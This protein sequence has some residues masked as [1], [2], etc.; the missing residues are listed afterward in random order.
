MK[1][2]VLLSK[3]FSVAHLELTFL[4]L[5]VW[6]HQVKPAVKI[7]FEC[8]FTRR[9]T[10]YVTLKIAKRL[11]L[12]SH[13]WFPKTLKFLFVIACKTSRLCFLTL[14]TI[15]SISVWEMISAHEPLLKQTFHKLDS[16]F[17]FKKTDALID[18]SSLYIS[19][20]V[21]IR[22]KILEVSETRWMK[23]YKLS[24]PSLNGWLF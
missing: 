6:L 7:Q 15:S 24:L 18:C 3:I 1:V 17:S 11:S 2:S 19:I 9:I 5:C 16:L 22:A 20:C 12:K 4:S 14:C 21:I 8:L 13:F 10:L 23:E